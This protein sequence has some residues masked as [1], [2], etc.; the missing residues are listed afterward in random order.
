[1]KILSRL[2]SRLSQALVPIVRVGGIRFYCPTPF[3]VW[4]AETLLTKEPETIAWINRMVPGE[5]FYDIG[6]NVGCYSL[7]AAKRGLHVVAFEPGAANYAVLMRNLELN[8]CP[9]R[10]EVFPVALSGETRV[11]MLGMNHTEAGLALH[12]INRPMGF[13]QPTMIYA[14]DELITEFRLPLPDHIKIDV[15][16]AED[17]V[18]RGAPK[19]LAGTTSIM[20]ESA[21]HLMVPGFNWIRSAGADVIDGRQEWNHFYERV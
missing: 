13:G 15:D 2:Q 12:G 14:L 9:G 8:P 17:S 1:M 10:F 7:Y 16:G 20:M 3:C 4:R 21:E 11:G 5:V 6:A 18:L 19:A